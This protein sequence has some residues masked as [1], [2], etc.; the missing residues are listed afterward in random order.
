MTSSFS[1]N[2]ERNPYPSNRSY[3]LHPLKQ[4]NIIIKRKDNE[5][6]TKKPC[7]AH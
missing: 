4:N 2:K 7:H 6:L 5:Y 3:P 1:S